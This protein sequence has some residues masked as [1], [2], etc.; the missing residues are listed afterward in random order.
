[1]RTIAA[2]LCLLG[3]TACH[4]RTYAGEDGGIYPGPCA[5]NTV[6][7]APTTSTHA[8]I[9][10]VREHLGSISIDRESRVFVTPEA[11]PAPAPCK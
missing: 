1:M 10:T 3:L 5:N 11:A 2:L 8:D 7:P 4:F 9:G 6:A